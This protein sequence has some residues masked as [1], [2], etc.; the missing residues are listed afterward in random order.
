MSLVCSN[1]LYLSERCLCVEEVLD[2][3]VDKCGL[4]TVHKAAKVAVD[5]PGELNAGRRVSITPPTIS[6]QLP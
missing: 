1:C 4:E 3:P 6:L 2:D 5:G